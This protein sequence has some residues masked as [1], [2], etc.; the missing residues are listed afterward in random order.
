MQRQ[1]DTETHHGQD[2]QAQEQWNK[3]IDEELRTYDLK[4]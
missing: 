3:K 4:K 2:K 1:Y